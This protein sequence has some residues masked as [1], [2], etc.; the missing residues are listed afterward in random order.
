MNYFASF[1]A[2]GKQDAEVTKSLP[3]YYRHPAGCKKNHFYSLPFRQAKAN[4]Y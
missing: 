2:L 4:I 1:Y 3:L